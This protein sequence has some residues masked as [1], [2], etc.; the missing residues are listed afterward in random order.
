MILCILLNTKEFAEFS[1]SVEDIDDSGQP[2]IQKYLDILVQAEGEGDD[3][4]HFLD[5]GQMLEK[6]NAL[7]IIF[8]AYTGRQLQ[9]DENQDVVIELDVNE[10][11]DR[12]FLQ[13]LEGVKLPELL[14]MKW[15]NFYEWDEDIE[16]LLSSKISTVQH[17]HLAAEGYWV[18]INDYLEHMLQIPW[19]KHLYLDGFLIDNENLEKLWEHTQLETLSFFSCNLSIEED[20]SL[21]FECEDVPSENLNNPSKHLLHCMI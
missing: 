1:N 6:I 12:E 14:G 9:V 11:G 8:Q 17:L 15:I 18:D 21:E 10:E 3:S 20:F 5:M 16:N 2:D 7:A 4:S 13:K 19:L